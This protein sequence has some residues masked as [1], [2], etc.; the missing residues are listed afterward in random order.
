MRRS[1][2]IYFF[3]SKVGK[4]AFVGREANTLAALVGKVK[5]FE[6]TC[7]CFLSDVSGR[8]ISQGGQKRSCKAVSCWA[9]FIRSCVT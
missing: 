8:V 9:R 3:H 1:R 6:F 7:F 4:S 2:D 5:Q